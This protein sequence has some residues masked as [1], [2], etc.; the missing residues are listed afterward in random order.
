MT[1]DLSLNGCSGGHESTVALL[2]PV[3]IG[4]RRNRLRAN[5]TSAAKSWT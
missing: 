1:I 5:T 2:A 3:P 4:G